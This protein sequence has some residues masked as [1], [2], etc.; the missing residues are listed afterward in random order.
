MTNSTEHDDFSRADG[1]TPQ[2]EWSPAATVWTFDPDGLARIG[3]MPEPTRVE[4]I[5]DKDRVNLYG[6]CPVCGAPRDAYM[7]ERWD[8]DGGLVKSLISGCTATFPINA[9][10]GDFGHP[11]D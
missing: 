10:N 11:Q 7:V 1:G 8:D 5:T 4:L 9:M 2:V 6:V 3:A